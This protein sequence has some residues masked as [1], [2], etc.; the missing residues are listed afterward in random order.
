MKK[1]RS[2]RT[3]KISKILE[4]CSEYRE[5]SFSEHLQYFPIS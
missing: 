3:I 4:N 2:L 5:Q 1:K